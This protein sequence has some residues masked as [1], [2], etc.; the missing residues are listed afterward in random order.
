MGWGGH[1]CG[2]RGLAECCGG[3]EQHAVKERWRGGTGGLLGTYLVKTHFGERL[4]GDRNVPGALHGGAVHC[5]E[6]GNPF[7]GAQTPPAGT[8]G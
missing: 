7:D 8:Q 6:V 3:G 1:H 5:Q 2:D 4:G